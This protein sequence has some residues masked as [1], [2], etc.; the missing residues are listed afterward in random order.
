[1]AKFAR[2][3]G[4]HQRLI[5]ALLAH[6]KICRQSSG[7]VSMIGKRRKSGCQPKVSFKYHL[8]LFEDN[9]YVTK[10]NNLCRELASDCLG[11]VS[12]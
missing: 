6:N 11:S 10:E 9:Q 12:K 3:I 2:Q 1:M 4:N 7:H 5:T 8:L